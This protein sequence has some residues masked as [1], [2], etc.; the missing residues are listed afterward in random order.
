MM[1]STASDGQ[2]V[3]AGRRSSVNEGMLRE[4]GMQGSGLSVRIR[5]GRRVRGWEASDASGGPA[6]VSCHQFSGLRCCAQNK[7]G[8]L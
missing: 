5:L 3:I 4:A 8:D 2:M 7:S 1:G 6:T